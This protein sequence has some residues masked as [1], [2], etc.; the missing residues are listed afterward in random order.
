VSS[1]APRPASDADH[2]IVGPVDHW[3]EVLEHLAADLGFGTFVFAGPSDPHTLRTFINEV[4]P[5]VRERVAGR[6][7][8]VFGGQHIEP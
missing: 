4:A 3:V 2:S 8:A 1:S 7:A 5:R 6:R